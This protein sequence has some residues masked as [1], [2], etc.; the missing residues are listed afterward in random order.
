MVSFK[1]FAV[2][3][4]TLISFPV[5]SQVKV[6]CGYQR[7]WNDGSWIS[8]NGIISPG[9]IWLRGS[10]VASSSAGKGQTSVW[11]FFAAAQAQRSS[12][13]CIYGNTVNENSNEAW[14]YWEQ[15]NNVSSKTQAILH[16]LPSLTWLWKLFCSEYLTWE[17]INIPNHEY[18]LYFR[19]MP[20]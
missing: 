11:T 9:S 16:I 13:L 19:E 14:L 12:P 20:K 6:F 3:K 4:S 17:I 5:T 18:R 10:S 15:E 2:V 7:W 8:S 1:A